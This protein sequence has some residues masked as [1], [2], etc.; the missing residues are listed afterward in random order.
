MVVILAHNIE[1]MEFSSL[2]SAI[3]NAKHQ[4]SYICSELQT[5]LICDTG[6]FLEIRALPL[7]SAPMKD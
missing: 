4:V 1:S 5:T 3:Y 6:Y 2:L 7:V